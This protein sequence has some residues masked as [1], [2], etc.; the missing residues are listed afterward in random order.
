[1][2]ASAQI[3]GPILPCICL[4]NCVASLQMNLPLRSSSSMSHV[5]HL[6]APSAR[7]E[8]GSA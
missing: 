1:M 4:A 6:L 8:R 2:L 5:L 3:D 7:F